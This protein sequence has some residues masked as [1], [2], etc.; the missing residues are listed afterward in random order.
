LESFKK[1]GVDGR[2][3]R[4]QFSKR[5][6]LGAFFAIASFIVLAAAAYGISQWFY[7][8][9]YVNAIT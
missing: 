3:K 8:H 6:S 7:K 9:Y 2:K 5:L 4:H 1:N